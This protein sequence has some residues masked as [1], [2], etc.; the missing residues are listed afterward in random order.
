MLPRGLKHNSADVNYV[1]FHGNLE[2]ILQRGT[3]PGDAR[4]GIAESQL[5]NKNTAHPTTTNEMRVIN[6]LKRD[7]N[8]ANLPTDKGGATVVRGTE[9][10]KEK[11]IQ[12]LPDATT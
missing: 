1:D 3:I 5:R 9:E 12:Q 8:I 2:S 4:R 11:A 7:C 10:Y 6:L